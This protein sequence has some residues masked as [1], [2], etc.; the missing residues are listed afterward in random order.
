M[1]GESDKKA[2]R[3]N[4]EI[5]Q[6]SKEEA[7]MKHFSSPLTIINW[8]MGAGGVERCAVKAK[9]FPS[10]VM[11]PWGKRTASWIQNNYNPR[12]VYFLCSYLTYACGAVQQEELSHRIGKTLYNSILE[13]GAREENFIRDHKE[14]KM[15]ILASQ[16]STVFR[17]GG[18]ELISLYYQTS[19]T[20]NEISRCLSGGVARFWVEL[21]K[22]RP[23]QDI[24]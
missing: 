18:E 2:G 13:I 22:V 6:K 3:V 11:T 7:P 19:K 12:N 15:K 14:D 5:Q 9:Q 16:I 24:S 10:V 17:A 4:V 20:R 23:G 21:G 8:K 1:P